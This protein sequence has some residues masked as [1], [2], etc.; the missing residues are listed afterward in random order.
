MEK[1]ALIGAN[2]D[3]KGVGCVSGK[4]RSHGVPKDHDGQLGE[5]A[6][7]SHLW[8]P[9]TNTTRGMIC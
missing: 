6:V 8:L 4:G 2:A 5:L 7:G 3:L 1:F 9:S